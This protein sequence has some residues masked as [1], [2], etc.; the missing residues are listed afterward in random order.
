MSTSTKNNASTEI[1]YS[2]AGLV[3]QAIHGDDPFMLLTFK[4]DVGSNQG[5]Y[6]RPRLRYGTYTEQVKFFDAYSTNGVEPFILAGY[7][8]GHGHADDNILHTWVLCVDFDYGYPSFLTKNELIRPSF[9]IE[10]SPN[11]YHAGWLLDAYCLPE[12]ARPI[13]KAM[14]DRLNGDFAYAKVSQLIRLPGFENKK[15]SA[16]SNL[17]HAPSPTK[18]YSLDFLKAAFDLELAANHIQKATSLFDHTLQVPRKFHDEAVVAQ[19]AKD[20]LEYL[21]SDADDYSTWVSTLMALVP[22]GDTGMKLAEE[23]SKHS[24]KYNALE[25]KKKWQNL[26]NTTGSVATIF[27]RAQK[28]GWKNPGF[29]NTSTGITQIITSRELGRMIA[30]ELGENYAVVL[31]DDNRKL[32]FLKWDGCTYKPISK[33]SRREIVE[34]VGNKVI[35]SLSERK[36]IDNATLKTLKLFLGTNRSLEEVCEHVADAM[37]RDSERRLVSAYPYFG[38]ANGVLNTISQELVP[39]KYRPIPLVRSPV[40]FDPMATAPLFKKTVTEI[41]EGDKEMVRYIY[42]LFGYILMGKRTYQ[43]FVV[44]LGPS[45]SNGKNTLADLLLH[46]LGDYAATLPITTIMTKSMVTDGATPTLARLEGKRLA[47]VSEPNAKHT[48]DSGAVKSLTGDKIF[49]VRKIYEDSKDIRLDF[50]L[51]MLANTLP[52]VRDNDHGLWRRMQVIPF[53]RHFTKE[54]ADLDLADKLIREASGILNIMLAG[55]SDYLTNPNGIQVP[56]KV[57]AAINQQKDEV[58]PLES[59]ISDTLLREEGNHIPLKTLYDTLYKDWAKQNPSFLPLTKK[60]FMERLES[61]GFK[62]YAKNNLTYFIGLRENESPAR[63]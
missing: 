33:T 36:S 56:D 2:D 29:R 45:S 1:K 61:K 9:C 16:F 38:V 23:F 28:N 11:H 6:N 54:E 5:T 44:F 21:T 62:K 43:W 4:R 25:F 50:L 52:V 12:V 49:S 47:V 26:Q 57:T 24:K 7:S 3:C 10:T 41:F 55:A 31:H 42:Q 58:D 51:L 18:V 40:I 37:V 8:D 32:I 48:I 46:L 60:Q 39:T 20:A 59:F 13:L 15:R 35:S 17:M 30:E 63:V 53:N 34:Q 22:L 14:A 19:D 27:L